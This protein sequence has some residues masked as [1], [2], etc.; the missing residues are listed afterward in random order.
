LLSTLPALGTTLLGMLAGL[1]LRSTHGLVQKIRGLAIAGVSCLLL[2]G[3]WN[4]TFP[5]NK[6]LWTSSYVLWAGGFSILLLALSMWL[7]DLPSAAEGKKE[8]SKRSPFFTPL[9]VF[10]TNAITAYV[11]SELLAGALGT[12]GPRPN[13][14]LQQVVYHFISGIVPNGAFASLT[15]S[16]CFVAFC[17]IPVYVLYRRRIFIKI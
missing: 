11:F 10:G 16:L 14:N 6:K 4:F 15:Y 7:V 5:I 8:R 17:W 1:W 9:L 3:L 2:G 12:F 13:L